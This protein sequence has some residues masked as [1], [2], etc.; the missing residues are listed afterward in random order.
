MDGGKTTEMGMAMGDAASLTDHFE[1]KLGIADI[2]ERDAYS[3]D[4]S[5]LAGGDSRPFHRGM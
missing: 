1:T 3:A 5:K 4:G 2:E